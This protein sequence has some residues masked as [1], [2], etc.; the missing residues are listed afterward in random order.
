MFDLSVSPQGD[1]VGVFAEK[2]DVGNRSRLVSFDK[3][4]LQFT[5]GTVGYQAQVNDPAD[6]I[7]AIQMES[8]LPASRPKS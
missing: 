8:P 3:L 5:G 6:F 2:Q 4:T 1:D 7:V